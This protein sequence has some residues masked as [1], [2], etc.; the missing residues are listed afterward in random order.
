MWDYTN[1]QVGSAGRF[2]KKKTSKV[3]TFFRTSWRIIFGISFLISLMI[4]IVVVVA[5]LLLTNVPFLQDQI[6]CSRYSIAD[7]A[8]KVVYVVGKQGSGSGFWVTPSI[9]L[10]NN[11]VVSFNEDIKVE[12]YD[13]NVYSATVIATDTVRDLALL[14]VPG[15]HGRVLE[16]STR[17]VGLAERV[18][19]IGYPGNV[20]MTITEGIVSAFIQDD[21]DDRGY[22]QTDS[23][24]NPGNSGGP[25]V[26]KCGRVVGVNTYT[27]YDSENIG[28]AIDYEQVQKRAYEL[29]EASQKATPEERVIGYPSE[30]AEVVAKYYDLLYAGE[31]EKAYDYYAQSRKARL[32]YDNWKKG[33]DNTV[34]IRFKSVE[35]TGTQ[36]VIKVNFLTTERDAT[37]YE[38]VTKE[39]AGEWTLV[40]ENNVWKMDQSNIKEITTKQE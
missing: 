12:D 33:F 30:Q 8:E 20:H 26:D 24:I 25:L 11:H 29:I 4:N 37:T 28:F 31:L 35:S 27:L 13:D 18:Y 15:D 21:Y 2:F 6:V 19:A 36:N 17:G 9:V 16:W 38:W 32:P 1:Y 22:I 23:A 14:E 39:F 34:S 10:T 5:V 3:V 7:A 40:R